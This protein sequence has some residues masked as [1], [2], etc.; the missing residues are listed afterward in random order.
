MGQKLV[1]LWT[2]PPVDTLVS[3][4]NS[5]KLIE[6]GAAEPTSSFTQRKNLPLASLCLNATQPKGNRIWKT[7]KGVDLNLNVFESQATQIDD[8]T[9]CYTGRIG[10]DDIRIKFPCLVRAYARSL[11]PM[12][13]NHHEQILENRP[14]LES[15]ISYRRLVSEVA[16]S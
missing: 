16:S 14:L 4:R 12:L 13:K 15:E 11:E 8:V 3:S 10:I 2:V 1:L 9:V 6:G 7:P 5:Q